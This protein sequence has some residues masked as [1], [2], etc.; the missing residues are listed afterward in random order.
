MEKEKEALLSGAINT[1]QADDIK[2]FALMLAEDLPDY[3]WHVGASSTGKYHP[4]YSLGEGGLIRHMI[5]TQTFLNHI[6][7]LEQYGF[8]ERE[9]DLM[10]VAALFH[11]G[12]KSGSQEEFE[13]DKYTKHDHPMLMGKHIMSYEGKCA[14]DKQELA[15][16]A[17]CIASHMGEWTTSRRS[18]VVLPKPVTL[19][20]QIVH[21]ADF[22]A[23]RKDLEVLFTK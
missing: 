3:I 20:Q 21:L 13:E 10:R 15:Y 14:L 1:I 19:Y 7:S 4:A 5:A 6:I 11:D 2:T 8:S 17:N 23:S 16:I 9:K 18:D 12:L 22:L